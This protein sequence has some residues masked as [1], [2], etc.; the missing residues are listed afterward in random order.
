MLVRFTKNP[1][2]AEADTLTC[3]RPDGSTTSMALRRPGVL[4][5]EAVHFVVEDALGWHDALFG[6]VAR[7]E[8]IEH[9]S[10]R[11]HGR[12]GQWAKITQALQSEA[13][14][15][16]LEADQWGGASDP[17]EFAQKL[18]TACRRRGTSPPDITA[19][20]LARVRIALREFGAA[21]RPLPAGGSL[22]RTFRT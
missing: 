15:E 14:V 4:P 21:W 19:D 9:V 1:L 22:D 2:P 16:C 11:L 18:V 10:A 17:A 13:L 5:H 8:L 12:N 7:G 20:E 6:H 3:V